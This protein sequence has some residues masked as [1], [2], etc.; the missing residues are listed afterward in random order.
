M[1]KIILSI[2][3]LVFVSSLL[4]QTP[5][6]YNGT[7]N[8]TGTDLKEALH[9]IINA[10]VDFSYSDAKYILNYADEDP[11]NTSNLIQLYTNRSV[12]KDS[13]G[14]GANE[15]NREHVWAKSHGA[16]A[17]IRPMD[18]DA[19][20]LHAADASTNVTRSNYDF[21][22]VEGGTYIEEADAYYNSSARTFEPADR[23]KGAIAR[24]IF[25]MAIRYEGTNGELDLKVV[26]KIDVSP[27]PEH[28]KLSTLLEWNK[29]FPPTDFEKRRNERVFQSQRNR[30]P[31]IDN[32]TFADY[33]WGSE[34]VSTTL[35]GGVSMS[36][37]QPKNGDEVTISVNVT[38]DNAPGVKLYWGNTYN[39]EDNAVDFTE[40][41]PQKASFTLSGFD[42]NELVYLKIK[43]SDNAVLHQSFYIAPNK[44]LTPITEVQGTGDASPI[45]NDIVTVSGVVTA[46]LDNSFYMQSGTNKYSGICVYSNWRGELGDSVTVTGKVV[47][48]QNLTEISNV[49]MVYSHGK[50]SVVTPVSLSIADINEN[51]EGMLVQ[52]NDVNFSNA[53]ETI[54]Y[55]GGTYYINEGAYTATVY[56]RY[57]SRLCGQKIPNGTVNVKAVV[58]QYKE[59]HQLLINDITWIEQGID[60]TAPEII[61]V[62]AVDATYIEVSF[63][64]KI[65][66]E[67]VNL[68]AFE[69]DGLT[70]TDAYY[71]PSTQAYLMVKGMEAKDYTLV[72]NGIQDLY[73]NTTTNASFDFTSE[74]VG[75]DNMKNEAF[76]VYPNPTNGIFTITSGNYKNI[77]AIEIYDLGGR[78]VHTHNNTF[79]ERTNINT[80]GVLDEGCYLVRV[81]YKNA[82]E[83]QKIIIK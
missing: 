68:N 69:I 12:S 22:N 64:E 58:S 54:P 63:N 28:G 44:T 38:S 8:L 45:E 70:I 50:G 60:I 18:G 42:D 39:S 57:D 23:D 24:T 20:N 48:Y 76:T 1:N 51:Y 40:S 53:D 71:Y 36:P 26:D 55:D 43:T 34:Q 33:I 81:S 78:L 31:F 10:H 73:G 52:L 5:G 72:V 59:N 80:E 27:A 83:T 9:E 61:G 21:D 19:H 47:E 79:S 3:S 49:T 66:Q 15:T 2:I 4:A 67:T 16:F 17:D 6:Y 56:V 14:T 62:K 65:D 25:Y 77:K 37:A 11:N 82:I 7:E 35:I 41:L 46:N 13:W 74:F 75:I 29:Q 30:N 32:P